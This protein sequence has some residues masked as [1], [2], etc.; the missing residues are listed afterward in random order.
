MISLYGNFRN[1]KFT[2]IYEDVN[3]FLYD[4]NNIGI[5]KKI[6]DDNATTLF[7]LLYANYGN[8]VIATSDENRFKYKLFSII[9]EYGPTWEY[10]LKLQ[11]KFRELIDDENQLLFENEFEYEETTDQLKAINDIK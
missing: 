1:R 8:S 5:P 11:D 3:A 7:Y 4:F 10:R 2:D 9:Y 6:T